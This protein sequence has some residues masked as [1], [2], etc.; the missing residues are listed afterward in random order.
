MFSFKRFSLVVCL[1]ILFH[2]PASLVALSGPAGSATSTATGQSGSGG[3]QKGGGGQ[4]SGQSTSA[5]SSGSNAYFE[6]QMLAYGAMKQLSSN[7]AARVCS[8]LKG[9]TTATL[10]IFDQASFQNLQAWQAFEASS[11]ALEETYRTFLDDGKYQT[12]MK[13]ADPDWKA[14]NPFSFFAGSDISGLVTALA[15]SNTNTASQFTMPDSALALSIVNQ[16]RTTCPESNGG[17]KLVY[18]PLLGNSTGRDASSKAVRAA[19]QGPVLLRQEVQKELFS[20]DNKP[21]TTDGKYAAFADINSV[22]D[23]WIETLITSIGQNQTQIQAGITNPGTP[24]ITSILQ[25]AQLENQLN[26]DNTYLLYA[27]I[28]AAGGTQKDIK[29]ILTVLFTGDWL[30]YS[31]GLVLN[32]GLVTTKTPTIVFGDTLSYRVNFTTVKKP[33]LILTSE[34]PNQGCTVLSPANCGP[35][36]SGQNSSTATNPPTG[37][38]SGGRK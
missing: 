32:V 14:E 20:G 3:S 23:Q 13:K 35:S 11:V 34:T 27:D 6:S 5:Q 25:G 9:K 16:I 4:S 24:G 19:M 8:E 1:T 33:E 10:L 37:S 12:I 2:E 38:P 22:Y 36:T 28:V 18:Y 21:T 29:N 17:P 7:I 15:A 31:G 30:H 26:E